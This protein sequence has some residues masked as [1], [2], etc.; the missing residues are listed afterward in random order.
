MTQD[1]YFGHKLRVTGAAEVL[2]ALER[3]GRDEKHG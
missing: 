3:A 1:R 2:E